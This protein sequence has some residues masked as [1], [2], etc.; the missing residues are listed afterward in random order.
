MKLTGKKPKK[1]A[2][3][4]VGGGARAAYQVGVLRAIAELLPKD[5]P[6]PFQIICG[7]SAGAI[8]A[9]SLA[10]FA[11]NFRSAVVRISSV[12]HNFHAHHV[13]RSDAISLSKNF[14]KWGGALIFGGLS[15]SNTLYLLDRQPLQKL[16]TRYIKPND[17]QRVIDNELLHALSITVSGYTTR[18]S[19]TFFQGHEDLQG[20][21][22]ARR[23]G[24][25]G[26]ITIDHL[27][28]SSAIPILFE[29][30]K[31]HR[32]FFGDGSMRQIA[33]LSASLHLGADKILVIGNRD[34]A[35]PPRYQVH[36]SPS[37]ANIA[38]YLLNSIFLDSLN[39]DLE[40]LNRVNKTVSLVSDNKLQ[41]KGV[42]LRSVDTLLISPSDDVGEMAQAYLSSLPRPIRILLKGIG[43]MKKDG[44]SLTSYLLF[45]KGYTR[46]LMDLG[47][48]D[49]KTKRKK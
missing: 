31:I 18:Q 48:K 2:L 26:N 39:A 37:L 3:V 28:A 6:C 49:A 38:G 34:E 35:E 11:D 47:Y 17:I 46:A 36:E 1:I 16:L 7:T 20:W 45:E 19:V 14:L 15:K 21:T 32:E 42:Q 9:A 8:N 29:P 30:V 43:A 44:S 24:C 5:A 33:P 4:M 13:F 12:W 41:K 40:R 25:R 23:I 27:M 10:C 22:R